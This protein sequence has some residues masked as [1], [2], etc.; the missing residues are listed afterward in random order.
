[1]LFAF[2]HW[3]PKPQPSLRAQLSLLL[4]FERYHCPCVAAA[5]FVRGERQQCMGKKKGSFSKSKEVLVDEEEV[6]K[7][8][9][10]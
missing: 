2:R 5:F 8:I 6:L 3:S 1:L 7:V 9:E 4:S 10:N